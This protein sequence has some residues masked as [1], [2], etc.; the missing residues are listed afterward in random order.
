MRK[1]KQDFSPGFHHKV[2]TFLTPT[3][4]KLTMISSMERSE[5]HDQITTHIKAR[6]IETENVNQIA[7]QNTL[8]SDN[9]LESFVS[10]DNENV[11]AVDSELLRYLNEPIICQIDTSKWWIDHSTV[12]P[13][14]YKMY[15][16]FSCIPATSASSERNFSTAGNIIT[17]KRS[18]LLPNNVNNLVIMRN[19]L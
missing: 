18:M 9:F 11:V 10:L 13:N 14:L 5:L 16:K 17:D 1:N 2:M 6:T 7:D 3:M 19:N 4:K 8:L 12:F 15:L